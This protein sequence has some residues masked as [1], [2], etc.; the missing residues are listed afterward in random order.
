MT[1]ISL[2]SKRIL[3]RIN[4]S[5]QKKDADDTEFVFT[6][7]GYI[8]KGYGK[9]REEYVKEKIEALEMSLY[10]YKRE[11]K[12][13]TQFYYLKVEDKEHGY[14][15]LDLDDETWEVESKLQSNDYQT[16]FTKK[17]IMHINEKLWAIAVPVEDDDECAV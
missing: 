8:P 6:R 11:L 5:L 7:G 13:L 10:E 16:R 1:E 3:E 2:Y 12:E 4:E 14:L 9:Q 17:E 15:N